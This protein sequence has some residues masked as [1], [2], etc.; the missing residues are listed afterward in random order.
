MFLIVSKN[1]R[2]WKTREI[3]R[4]KEFVELI[5]EELWREKRRKRY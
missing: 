3:K 2:M 4:A 5:E 1:E